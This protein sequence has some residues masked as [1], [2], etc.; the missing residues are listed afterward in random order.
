MAYFLLE[1]GFRMFAQGPKEYFFDAINREVQWL[2]AVDFVVV[3][4]SVLVDPISYIPNEGDLA[5]VLAG[6]D[7]DFFGELCVHVDIIFFSECVY[8]YI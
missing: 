5:A 3:V 8:I 7:E 4:G 2:N 6:E 1:I